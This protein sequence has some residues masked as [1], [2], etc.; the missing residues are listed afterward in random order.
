[1]RA[2]VQAH[3]QLLIFMF[4]IY[5]FL[6]MGVAQQIVH[7]VSPPRPTCQ[8]LL[9]VAFQLSFQGPCTLVILLLYKSQ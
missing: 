9:L 4:K 7:R 5:Y 3:F 6:Q 1:M 2:E 8:L